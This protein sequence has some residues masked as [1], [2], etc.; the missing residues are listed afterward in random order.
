MF[1]KKVFGRKWKNS[2]LVYPGLRYTHKKN[3][4]FS[5]KIFF[6]KCSFARKIRFP[7]N[8]S[9]NK[10]FRAISSSKK[11]S[12]A[13]WK[14]YDKHFFDKTFSFFIW[15]DTPNFMPKQD[16]FF[17]K[18][19]DIISAK[20]MKFV[21]LVFFH[22][23]SLWI[24]KI[25]IFGLWRTT[26]ETT[27]YGMYFQQFYKYV[28]TSKGFLYTDSKFS[29]LYVLSRGA[30]KWLLIAHPGQFG[31]TFSDYERWPDRKVYC[32]CNRH[33]WNNESRTRKLT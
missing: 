32:W 25:S 17:R 14:L 28:H 3:K 9:K 21:W 2:M 12:H 27:E 7:V 6:E 16:L 23:L 13:I 30:L 24:C 20:C 10:D 18:F 33:F 19:D 11:A 5:C 4:N 8:K 15:Y 22:W 1:L 26:R 29:L 31:A